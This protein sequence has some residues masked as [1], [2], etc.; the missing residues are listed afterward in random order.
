MKLNREIHVATVVAA[1][2]LAIVLVPAFCQRDCD[3][4]G[5]NFCDGYYQ[6]FALAIPFVHLEHDLKWVNTP[7]LSGLPHILP[8]VIPS[9][10]DTRAPP[11]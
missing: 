11:V 1:L 10:A 9:S 4:Q 3:L 6:I 8:Q 2:L 7:Y 5:S